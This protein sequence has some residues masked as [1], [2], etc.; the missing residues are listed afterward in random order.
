MPG[1]SKWYR[2]WRPRSLQ[3]RQLL[4]ASLSLVAFLALAGY[5]LD[6]AFADTAEKN[7]RER[8]KN[9]ASAYAANIDFVRDGS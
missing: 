3:A 4:A 7:L 6:V 1:R 9:Y 5:A 8:L 2:R